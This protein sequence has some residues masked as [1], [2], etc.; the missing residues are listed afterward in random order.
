MKIECCVCACVC[1]CV[2][3]W[4]GGGGMFILLFMTCSYSVHSK[5]L[6]YDRALKG[7]CTTT[8]SVTESQILFLDMQNVPNGGEI[9]GNFYRMHVQV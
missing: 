6:Q 3:V 2:C 8:F 7:S 9:P 4:V 1:A 5:L